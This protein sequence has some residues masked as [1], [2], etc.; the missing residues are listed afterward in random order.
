MKNESIRGFFSRIP[1]FLKKYAPVL[2]IGLVGVLLLLWPKKDTDRTEQPLSAA[3]A[4]AQSLLETEQRLAAL[5]SRIDGAGE[6]QLMLS[7]RT[8]A[9]TVYQTDTKRSSGDSGDTQEITT[10]L[11]AQSGT[12]KA[13]LIRKTEYPVYLGAVVVCMGADSAQVRLAIVEAVSSLTGL[14]SD[15]ITVV[16]MKRQ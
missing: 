11:Y 8:G 15:N 16:K 10:V 3:Q 9:E 5:L 6:V 14:G 13:P 1:G 12:S 7:L 4:P 2:V